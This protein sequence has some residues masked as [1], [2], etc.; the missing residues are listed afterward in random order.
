[1]QF[2]WKLK[3]GRGAT[4]HWGHRNCCSSNI[5]RAN[6]VSRDAAPCRG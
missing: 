6:G 1:M 2:P 5:K 4:K 3:T